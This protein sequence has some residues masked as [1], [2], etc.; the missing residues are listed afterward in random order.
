MPQKLEL[1]IRKVIRDGITDFIAGGALG[2]DTLAAQTILKLRTEYPHIR[3]ILALPCRNQTKNWRASD[4]LIYEQICR[5]ADLVYYLSDSYDSG[6]MMRRNRFMVD[7]S[8]CCIFYLVRSGSGTYKTVSYAMD[9]GLKLYNV[10]T[11]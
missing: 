2:F 10:L 8:S 6:C 1:I 5:K 3:L 11:D 7:N 4:K 9:N